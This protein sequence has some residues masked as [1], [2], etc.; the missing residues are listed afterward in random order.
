MHLKSTQNP[1]KFSLHF[2]LIFGFIL[3]GFFK[4]F[5]LFFQ[6]FFGSWLKRLDPTKVSPLPVKSRV[7]ASLKP[8]KVIK[9]SSKKSIKFC[10]SFFHAF[11]YRLGR[12]L[13]SFLCH[14][15][16]EFPSKKVSEISLIF[17][18]DFGRHLVSLG[19]SFRSQNCFQNSSRPPLEHREPL[20]ACPGAS[21]TSKVTKNGARSEP[22]TLKIDDLDVPRLPKWSPRAPNMESQRTPDFQKWSLAQGS[23]ND[24][25]MN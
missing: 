14:F 5:E 1:F 6:W 13:E 19:R 11:W 20:G 24:P 18:I 9:K 23:Q 2:L 15:A 25:K 3:E 10:M 8:P 16:I 21:G 22:R 7:W 17:F 12:H 4:H